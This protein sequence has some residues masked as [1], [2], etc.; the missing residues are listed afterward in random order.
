MLHQVMPN[1]YVS[2]GGMHGRC[3]LAQG[4]RI[5]LTSAWSVRDSL[6][7]ESAWKRSLRAACS[8]ALRHI[9]FCL[10]PYVPV[11]LSFFKS[12]ELF[13]AA[14]GSSLLYTL[15]VMFCHLQLS[16]SVGFFLATDWHRVFECTYSPVE[17]K[18]DTYVCRETHLSGCT[19][20][21]CC[22]LVLLQ[23]HML[24]LFEACQN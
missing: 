2:F 22:C 17:A 15:N 20:A 12:I 5:N 19:W 1:A 9:S 10:P 13:Q 14:V 16:S 18:F 3:S 6:H 21:C 24:P 7:C 23:A 8:H 11:T 4:V